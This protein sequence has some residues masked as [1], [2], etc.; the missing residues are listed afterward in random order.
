[1]EHLEAI[2]KF[3]KEGKN[4]GALLHID[5]DDFKYINEVH[6]H[7]TGDQILRDL[8]LRL[9]EAVQAKH[10]LARIGGGMLLPYSFKTCMG[11]VFRQKNWQKILQ[12]KF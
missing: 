5:L 3:N 7:A 8:V 1:M 6:G 9:Q 10:Y 4:F 12:I 2:E 11:I